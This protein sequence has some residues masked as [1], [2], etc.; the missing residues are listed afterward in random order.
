MTK[1][2]IIWNIS[3]L[4]CYCLLRDRD[5]KLLSSDRSDNLIAYW[6]AYLPITSLMY[7]SVVSCTH[8]SPICLSMFE[9]APT[10]PRCVYQCLRLHLL[11]PK[12]IHQCLMLHLL[13]PNVYINVWSWTYLSPMCMSMYDAASTCAQ[14]VG[15]CVRLHL[16]VPNVYTMSNAAS[17]CPQYVHQCPRLH[18]PAPNVYINV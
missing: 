18:Q 16:V 3:C 12:C 13:F 5:K 4:R 11:N 8:L 1:L 7:D 2:V 14:C 15:Q 6:L 17:T 10:C 9:A